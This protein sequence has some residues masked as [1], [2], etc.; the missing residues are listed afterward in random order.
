MIDNKK[1]NKKGIHM[2][3]INIVTC[4]I[5]A[6][7]FIHLTASESTIPFPTKLQSSFTKTPYGR[8]DTNSQTA[9]IDNGIIAHDYTDVI[10]KKGFAY[11]DS[12]KIA[13][14]LIA[15]KGYEL[16]GKIAS[17]GCYHGVKK[18]VVYIYGKPTRK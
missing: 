11:R 5:I 6:F 16:I 8:W 4:I 9:I 1:L 14:E 3:N 2:Q 12:S 7:G 17:S 13:L 10:T 15:P 18:S